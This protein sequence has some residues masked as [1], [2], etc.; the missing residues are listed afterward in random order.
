[1]FA[2][3][4]HYEKRIVNGA[5]SGQHE[6]RGLAMTNGRPD[7]KPICHCEGR[8]FFVPRS[9]LNQGTML[10]LLRRWKTPAC[11]SR[12][13][14]LPARGGQ[15]PKAGLTERSRQAR[16]DS[17]VTLTRAVPYTVVSETIG[18][19]EIASSVQPRRNGDGPPRNDSILQ[20]TFTCGVPVP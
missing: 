12:L 17:G 5:R 13:L 2:Q 7:I 1:M 6:T 8:L 4:L 3:N 18:G 20:G 16:N 10:R 19:V 14:G 11:R 15:A 9:D